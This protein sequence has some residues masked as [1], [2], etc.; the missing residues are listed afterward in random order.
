MLCGRATCKITSSENGENHLAIISDDF[1]DS[2]EEAF[3]NFRQL[4][5]ADSFPPAV[6]LIRY[7]HLV[8]AWVAQDHG[9]V[10]AKDACFQLD[11]NVSGY[12]KEEVGRH[13]YYSR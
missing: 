13:M 2:A 12:T 1:L 10:N 9:R 5:G 6:L 4:R 11:T 3:G 7:R 8:H